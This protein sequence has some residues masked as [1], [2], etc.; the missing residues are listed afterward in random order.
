MKRLIAAV[1]AIFVMGISQA[2]AGMVNLITNGSFE[3]GPSDADPRWNAAQWITFGLNSAGDANE[4]DGW[5]VDSA[6]QIDLLRA[7]S[8]YGD[9]SD[10]VRHI[11]LTGS[12]VKGKIS[13]TI[14]TV[15]G[16][17]YQ[18]SF[19]LLGISGMTLGGPI[20]VRSQIGDG[21]MFADFAPSLSETGWITQQWT[22]TAVDSSSTL[23]F[24]S[25]Y[26]NQFGN[27]P[28]IDNVR[29]VEAPLSVVPEPSSLVLWGVG[30]MGIFLVHRR[31]RQQTA[32]G[33]EHP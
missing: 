18:V 23:Q 28:H 17:T 20:G 30:M 32:A 16:Q 33:P 27:G 29:V 9:A 11:D 1:L 7:G 19:D 21:A 25:L 3:L 5:T 24:L 12:P 6:G 2:D 10:G 22:F 15:V 13:Q 14:S 8:F 31:S 4:I 26:G